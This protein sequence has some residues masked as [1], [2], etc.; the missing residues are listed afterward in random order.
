M[1]RGHRLGTGGERPAILLGSVLG[2]VLGE[3]AYAIAERSDVLTR[4][5]MRD[6]VHDNISD[7]RN[8]ATLCLKKGIP[9][10]LM[11]RSRIQ[12]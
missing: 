4:R 1:L 5:S 6:R 7:S 9:A 11:F 12:I 3:N 8:G 10:R 2:S